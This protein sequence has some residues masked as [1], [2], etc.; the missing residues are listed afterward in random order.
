MAPRRSHKIQAPVS[1]SEEDEQQ[2]SQDDE[3]AAAK[4]VV[5]KNNERRDKK[6]RA[7]EAEHEKRVKDVKARIDALFAARK[8][9]VSKAHQAAWARLDALDKKRQN[10][11][12]LIL[13]TMKNIETRSIQL[14]VE[15]AVMFEDRLEEMEDR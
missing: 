9:R 12:G 4:E 11:E 14:C 10:I 15:L 3:V 8:S 2:S 13:G 5:T 7:I 6:R 1:A